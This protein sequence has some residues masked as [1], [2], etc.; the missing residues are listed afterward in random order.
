MVVTATRTEM[1]LKQAP[2]SMSVITAQDIEDSP[3][4]TLADIVADSTSVEV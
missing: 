3:G 4:I 1:A 2:A